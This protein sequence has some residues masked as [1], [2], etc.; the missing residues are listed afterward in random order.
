MVEELEMKLALAAT[1]LTRLQQELVSAKEAEV[2]VAS[3]A[4]DAY[5][6]LAVTMRELEDMRKKACAASGSCSATCTLELNTSKLELKKALE[7][8]ESLQ[9]NLHVL[10]GELHRIRREAANFQD[11]EKTLNETISTLNVELE[12]C[13]RDLTSA[14]AAEANASKAVGIL[15][16]A[17]QQAEVETNEA[18][19]KADTLRE[20]IARARADAEYA[21]SSFDNVKKEMQV[22]I[23]ATQDAKAAEKKAL[24][25]VNILSEK[26]KKMQFSASE[27]DI[28]VSLSEYNQLKRKMQ[29]T[30]DLANIRIA[31]AKVQVE[32]IRKCEMELEQKVNTLSNELKLVKSSN[33]QALYRAEMAEQAKQHIVNE[34]R[35]WREHGKGHERTTDQA[36]RKYKTGDGDGTVSNQLVVVNSKVHHS[37]QS[38]KQAHE[39]LMRV[40]SNKMTS[41]AKDSSLLSDQSISQKKKKKKHY[42]LPTMSVFSSKKDLR[43]WD[44]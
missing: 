35:K 44:P 11:R 29:E 39:S 34:M 23:E 24:E 3:A 27:V 28:S 33:E 25:Q 30:E 38:S 2:K 14:I 41:I 36:N 31:A 20:E 26:L 19:S 6:S 5:A 9:A 16:Q 12:E 4:S 43:L 10:Q 42:V 1:E 15:T 18:S 32:A 13:R 21:R 22:A 8:R 17:L 7:D 37:R 40:F